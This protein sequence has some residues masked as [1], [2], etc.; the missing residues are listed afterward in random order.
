VQMK[1]TGKTKWGK[2]LLAATLLVCI[3]VLLLFSGCGKE[4]VYRVGILSGLDYVMVIYDGFKAQMEELGY[5]EGENINYDFQHS[6]VNLD[7]Y[8]QILA[9]FNT[10]K[11]DLIFCYPTEAAIAAKQA[12]KDSQIPVVFDFSNIEEND[13]VDSIREPGGNVT[14]VRY[15]G[16]GIAIRRFEIM[17]ELAPE[18]K[19]YWIPYQKGSPTAPE[20]MKLLYP[21]A[22]QAGVTIL[23]TPADNA[24]ELEEILQGFDSTGTVFDAVLFLAEPLT[25][26]PDAF[27]VISNYAAKRKIPVGGAI[28]T[29]GDYGSIFGVNTDP[30]A[31]GKQ[32]A[33][34]ADKILKG[35]DPGTLPVISAEIFLEINYTIGQKAGV[36]ISEGILSQANNIIR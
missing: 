15:P 4:R 16:P 28:M 8:E 6:N 31:S 14:G 23:E 24:A 3:T 20:Q 13:I 7:E 25:V 33:T 11:V 27:A 29:E 30:V 35:A 1:K 10:D 36:K 26:T 21:A 32:A 22:E 19:R 34:L 9:K 5:V 12:T 2:S 18:A 17:R